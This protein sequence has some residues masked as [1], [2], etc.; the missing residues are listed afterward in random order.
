[1]AEPLGAEPEPAEISLT[2]LD[3]E[4]PSGARFEEIPRGVLGYRIFKWLLLLVA[5]FIALLTVY[6]FLTYPKLADS[7]TLAGPNGDA[8]AAFRQARADWL[9]SVKDLGQIFLITPVLPLIGAVLGYIFG[10]NEQDPG[11]SGD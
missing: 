10:R 7:R 6:G 2:Q 11:S 1:M 9:S 8:V 4:V 3:S 5:V